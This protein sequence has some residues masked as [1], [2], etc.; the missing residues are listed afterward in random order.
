[1][2]LLHTTLC[3]YNF[4][5][6]LTAQPSIASGSIRSNVW[7]RTRE[8]RPHILIK[9]VRLS[10]NIFSFFILPSLI[11]FADDDFI[12]IRRRSWTTVAFS[13][14]LIFYISPVSIAIMTTS[15]SIS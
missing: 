7:A 8:M 10:G 4:T 9:M 6:M 12:L 13:A 1:M 11:D 15:C 3:A 2:N 14:A 5:S